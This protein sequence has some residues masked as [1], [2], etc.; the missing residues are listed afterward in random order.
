MAKTL[1]VALTAAV[2]LAA[3]PQ[4]ASDAPGVTVSLH[5]AEVLHRTGVNYPAEAMRGG[6]QGTV[7][8]E[9]KLDESGE[10][11]DAQVLTGPEE[12]RKPVLESVLHWHFAAA[13]A[14]STRVVDVAFVAPKTVAGTSGTGNMV[15][16]PGTVRSIRVDGLSDAARAQLLAALP[17]HEGDQWNT[18][19][20]QQATEAVRAFDEH[21]RILPSSM[22]QSAGGA[23]VDLVIAGTPTRIKVGGNVQSAMIIRRAV[24]VYPPEA[25]AARVQGEVHL[26]VVIGTDGT[27]QQ[28]IVLDG[29]A[30]LVTAATDA[31]KQ[32]VYKPTLLNGNPVQVETSI[33]VNF[34]LAN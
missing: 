14:G 12:L 28:V 24:P 13:A 1:F 31:V 21:L 8:V 3:A 10:V 17:L 5:G 18:A 4:A 15:V 29:P 9:V 16:R 11:T 33:T 30:E 2:I 25:K 20:A 23:Q 22:T 32:W 7:S 34:T 27:V 26:A 6:I 19:S